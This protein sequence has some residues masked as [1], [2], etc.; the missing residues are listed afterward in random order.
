MLPTKTTPFSNKTQN[1]LHCISRRRGGFG[2]CVLGFTTAPL[3]WRMGLIWY[4]FGS[5]TTAS[6]NDC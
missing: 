4:G 5:G 3:P 1:T 6:T 2:R